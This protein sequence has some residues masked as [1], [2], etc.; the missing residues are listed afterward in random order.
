MIVECF[1]QYSLYLILTMMQQESRVDRHGEPHT[2]RVR[3][4]PLFLQKA[5]II[6]LSGFF[7]SLF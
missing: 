5:C 3:I 1:S 7:A 4:K 2:I 6:S